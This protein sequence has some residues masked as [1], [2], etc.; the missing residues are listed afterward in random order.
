M[1]INNRERADH[2]SEALAAYL[3]SKGEY[4]SPKPLD[5]FIEDYE[6]SDLICDLLH[7]SDALGFGA[8]QQISRALIHY[9]PEKAEG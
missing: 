5:G 2:A 1:P 6:I 8:A 9:G 3:R 4:D 7:L